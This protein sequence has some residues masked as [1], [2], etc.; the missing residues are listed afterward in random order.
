M[1]F[2]SQE[3]HGGETELCVH[4]QG[5][6]DRLHVEV[7][8]QAQCRRHGG[9]CLVHLFAQQLQ[10]GFGLVELF[11]DAQHPPVAIRVILLRAALHLVHDCDVAIQADDAGSP[12]GGGAAMPDARGV[13]GVKRQ[14]HRAAQGAEIE[15]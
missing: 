2:N 14:R 1:E 11:L 15:L 6:F 8:A 4:E 3:I 13:V 9:Q 7:L 10:R 12:F 5:E